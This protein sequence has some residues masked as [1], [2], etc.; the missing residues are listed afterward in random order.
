MIDFMVRQDNGRWPGTSATERDQGLR[1]VRAGFRE[2]GGGRGSSWEARIDVVRGA[3][4][5]SGARRG[6][7]GENDTRGVRTK[8][9]RVRGATSEIDI[10][11]IVC[12]N[13]D[14]SLGVV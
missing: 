11:G 12:A 5:A 9:A 6:A 2:E 7:V 13:R 10:D 3:R 1:G 4:G 14:L 8:R